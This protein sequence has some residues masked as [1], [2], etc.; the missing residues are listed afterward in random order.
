[1]RSIKSKLVRLENL[2]KAIIPDESVALVIYK[3]G[4]EPVVP[5]KNAKVVICIPDN[6]RGDYSE[7]N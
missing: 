1:M 7:T 6:G 5:K 2:E 4:E 3:V